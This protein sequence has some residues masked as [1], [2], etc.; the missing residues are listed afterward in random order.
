MSKMQAYIDSNR[1]EFNHSQVE[2]LLTVAKM[3]PD[4]IQLI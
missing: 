4:H 2:V 3:P 1:N